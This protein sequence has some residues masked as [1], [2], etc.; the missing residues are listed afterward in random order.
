MPRG[1]SARLGI[2]PEQLLAA[3]P[4]TG[5]PM[6]AFQD[7]IAQVSAA[8]PDGTRRAYATYWQRIQDA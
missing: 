2:T 3:S 5:R 7:F 1:C 4:A 6:P 8:V